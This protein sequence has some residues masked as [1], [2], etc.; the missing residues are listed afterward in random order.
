MP[1]SAPN[2]ETIAAEVVR[3]M[4]GG[5]GIIAKQGYRFDPSSIETNDAN[6]EECFDGWIATD[7]NRLIQQLSYVQKVAATILGHR[8]RLDQTF[9]ST[10]IENVYRA[11]Y[12]I[13]AKFP[14]TGQSIQPGEYYLFRRNL[15]FP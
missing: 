11:R 15:S 8:L 2:S 5:L 4:V 7:H 6:V 12:R 14:L 13:S 10:D 1:R 3:S 9:F